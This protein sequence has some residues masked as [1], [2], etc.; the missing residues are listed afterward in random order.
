MPRS[1]DS[2]PPAPYNRQ[3]GLRHP[4][5]QR[6]QPIKHG[7]K[8]SPWPDPKL[9]S[10]LLANLL[11]ASKK[12][13]RAG[14]QIQVCLEERHKALRAGKP[15]GRAGSWQERL[16]WQQRLLSKDTCGNSPPGTPKGDATTFHCIDFTVSRKRIR[17]ADPISSTWLLLGQFVTDHSRSVETWCSLS[18]TS[19]KPDAHQG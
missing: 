8:Q 13:Q 4:K 18:P 12:I 6:W 7:A 15:P 14:F 5:T 2:S 9:S 3:D 17:G 16:S 10:C 19:W 11:V 1:G